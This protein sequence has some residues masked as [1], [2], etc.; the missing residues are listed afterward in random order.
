VIHLSTRQGAQEL[1]AITGRYYINAMQVAR[2]AEEQLIVNELFST[3]IGKGYI[4]EGELR[5]FYESKELPQ[6]IVGEA[7]IMHIFTRDNAT[8]QK[9][10]QELAGGI[11]FSE[12]ARKYSEG[13]ERSI[14]GDLGYIKESEFPEFFSVA[15]TLK[16][17]E[18]SHVI[19]TEY[20]YHI[21]KMV[22]YA[23]ARRNS[24]NNLK[25]ALLAEL[26]TV[27]R[28]ENIRELLNALHNNANIQY[29]S[30]FTLADLFPQNSN[31]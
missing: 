2:L 29:L 30:N 20:G 1:K 5:R 8:A 24:Y 7:H 13:T 25:P 17:G 27:K 19:Q 28:Q 9:A 18:V 23:T 22:N 6:N 21:F 26:Y 16:E 15:F 11:I 14:G 12:V 10:A 3:L 4:T 31:N